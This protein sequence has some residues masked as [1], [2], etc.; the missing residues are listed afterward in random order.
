MLKRL[1]T[2]KVEI[3]AKINAIATVESYYRGGPNE[4]LPRARPSQG[5]AVGAA[6]P[7]APTAAA[8]PQLA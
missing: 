1:P 2:A 4:A 6:S 8:D 7:T 3:N 5:L